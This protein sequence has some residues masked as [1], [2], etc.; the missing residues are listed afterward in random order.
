[1]LLIVDPTL[2]IYWNIYN[3]GTFSYNIT[4]IYTG[5]LKYIQKHQNTAASEASAD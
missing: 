3:L 5:K 4:I 2:Y 1:M